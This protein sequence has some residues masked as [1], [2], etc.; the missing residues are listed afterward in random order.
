MYF[1]AFYVTEI[2]YVLKQ[3]LGCPYLERIASS[4]FRGGVLLALRFLLSAFKVKSWLL[5]I[6]V[7]GTPST[8]LRCVGRRAHPCA[9]Q[10]SLCYFFFHEPVFQQLS[11]ITALF[12]LYYYHYYYCQIKWQGGH[13]LIVSRLTHFSPPA[14]PPGLDFSI[15]LFST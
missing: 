14:P 3:S 2:L 11:F 6:L 7:V 4:Y 13:Y 15:P 1:Y 12:K 8:N 5:C 10:S 9:G